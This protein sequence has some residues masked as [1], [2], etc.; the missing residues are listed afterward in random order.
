MKEE[1]KV[2]LSSVVIVALTACFCCFLLSRTET[3]RLRNS[4]VEAQ[5]ADTLLKSDIILNCNYTHEPTS[6]CVERISKAFNLS[7]DY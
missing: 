6:K 7:S 4:I 3:V 1:N 2:I 5:R